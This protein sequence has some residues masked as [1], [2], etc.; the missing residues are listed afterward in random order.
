MCLL[1][2]W[3]QIS[4]GRSGTVW[5]TA[6][7]GHEWF[8]GRRGKFRPSALKMHIGIYDPERCWLICRPPYLIFWCLLRHL[9][10]V[11]L[12]CN[13][14]NSVNHDAE[15][16]GS[17]RLCHSFQIVTLMF[18]YCSSDWGNI[19]SAKQFWWAWFQSHIVMLVFVPELCVIEFLLI[20]RNVMKFYN[21]SHPCKWCKW[22]MYT[23]FFFFSAFIRCHYMVWPAEWFWHQHWHTIYS[24]SK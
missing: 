2:K 3:R 6:L 22:Y 21:I 13:T 23:F 8:K 10:D 7:Q 11:Q 4:G 5:S 17:I 18:E 24:L 12:F 1:S 9:N 19:S 16:D 15:Q 20:Q 14:E